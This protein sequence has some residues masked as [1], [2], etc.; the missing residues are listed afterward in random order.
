MEKRSTKYYRK[1]E[2]KVMKKLGLVPT[3]NSGAGFEEKEDGYNEYILAQLK[4]TDKQSISMKMDDVHKLEYHAQVEHK[5]PVFVLQFLEND[6]VFIC[7]RPNDIPLVSQYLEL[8]QCSIPNTIEIPTDNKP[9]PPK[10]VISSGDRNTFWDEYKK[11]KGL[12]R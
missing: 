7:M 8:G 1:N 2:A 4:S 9:Q 6:D 12:K 11:E 3:K 10:D 5:V